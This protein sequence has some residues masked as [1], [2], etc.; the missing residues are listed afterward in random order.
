MA[1]EGPLTLSVA[2]DPGRYTAKMLIPP[3]FA[4]VQV[5]YRNQ[6]GHPCEN[7]LGFAVT[8]P[9]TQSDVDDLSIV[10]S[11]AWAAIL[12]TSGHYDGL[13]VLEGNDG[14]PTEFISITDA[15]PGGRGGAMSPPQVQHMLRKVT[16]I[17]GRSHRGRLFIPC[18]QED[19]VDN[20]GNLSGSTVFTLLANVAPVVLGATGDPPWGRGQ[21]LHPAA[22]PTEL[23]DCVTSPTV[24]T[25]RRRF[26]T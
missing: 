8:A 9:L 17:S 13:R 2:D 5:Q 1:S 10:C 20:S 18:V 23:S 12:S 4:A 11:A 3:G 19:Q 21:L 16:G 26:R 22:A 6:I 7:V 25:L 24:A 15:G 14:D